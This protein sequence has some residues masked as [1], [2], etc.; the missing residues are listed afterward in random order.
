MREPFLGRGLVLRLLIFASPVLISGVL[1]LIFVL[2]PFLMSCPFGDFAVCW[3]PLS[4]P[5]PPYPAVVLM[6]ALEAAQCLFL[7]V[8][9]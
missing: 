1:I 2:F 3:P 5:R 4:P 7:S 6:I 9:V 8:F